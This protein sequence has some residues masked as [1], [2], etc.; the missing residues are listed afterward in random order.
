MCIWAP[1]RPEVRLFLSSTKHNVHV[2]KDTGN[3][4]FT[5]AKEKKTKLLT[6]QGLLALVKASAPFIE[7][8]ADEPADADEGMQ[9]D[10]PKLAAG[11]SS[12]KPGSSRAGP[13]HTAS[14]AK[15]RD[16]GEEHVDPSTPLSLPWTKGGGCCAYICELYQ[17]CYAYLWC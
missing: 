5:N 13:S 4:K 6:E 7:D 9:V 15:P 2:G 10:P 8:A 16:T 11:A 3:S 1:Y 17:R 14:A 12:S